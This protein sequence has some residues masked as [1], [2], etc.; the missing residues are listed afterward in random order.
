MKNLPGTL[1][2]LFVRWTFYD[3]AAISG[4]RC[5]PFHYGNGLRGV[6][7]RL[8]AICFTG[9]DGAGRD[10]MGTPPYVAF[11]RGHFGGT[12]RRWRPGVPGSGLYQASAADPD[13]IAGA[14]GDGGRGLS[15]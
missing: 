11:R 4:H 13:L 5:S 9:S 10:A 8:V 7:S 14:S 1:L 3:I 2:D 6:T 12:E 15:C